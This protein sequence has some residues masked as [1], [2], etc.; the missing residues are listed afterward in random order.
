MLETLE[1]LE[2]DAAM[3]WSICNETFSLTAY[4]AIAAGAAL[5]TGPDSGNVAALAREG[6]HGLVLTEAE[7]MTQIESGA[8]LKLARGK[9]RPRLYDLAYSALTVD[10]LPERQP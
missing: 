6:G 1:D 10:L 5:V 8:L 9:R 4:E 7:L 2:V 3:V